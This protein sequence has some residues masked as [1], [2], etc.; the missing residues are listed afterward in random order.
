MKRIENKR[1]FAHFEMVI[2]FV[3]FMGFMAFL[4]TVLSFNNTTSIPSTISKGLHDNFVKMTS[5]IY[6]Q[7]FS[8]QI[9][10]GKMIVSILIYR[11]IF[12]LTK[13]LD[14]TSYIT[15]LDGANI[16][17]GIVG[18]QLSIEKNGVF[19][20]VKFS[21]EFHDE[22]LTE[23]AKLNDFVLGQPVDMKVMSYS[24][25]EKMQNEY[26]NNYKK[27]QAELGVPP[28]FDFAID[29]NALSI[30][31]EPKQIPNSVD[32]IAK[33]YMIEVL[34]SDGTLTNERFILKIW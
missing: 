1:G 21:P 25:L 15:N 13:F 17:S 33:D 5:T 20:N 27:L 2:S 26:F 8:K 10:P 19:F 9:I 28:T 30:K 32:I 34:K 18:N 7:Y 23:C 22:G 3:F 16:S 4:F 29:D 14:G 12:S 11:R 6:Q 24:A 31:M